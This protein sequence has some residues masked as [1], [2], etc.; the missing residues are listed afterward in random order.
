VTVAAPLRGFAPHANGWSKACG[1]CP[2][3]YSMHEW[4]ALPAMAMLPQSSVQ[5]HL[6]VPAVWG[7][8]LRRCACGAVL[9]ARTPNAGRSAGEG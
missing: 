1:L 3:S 4:S 2:R 8:E 6:S 5:A 9:A 7:V